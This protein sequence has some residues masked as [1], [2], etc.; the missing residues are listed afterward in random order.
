[1][2]N[3]ESTFVHGLFEKSQFD[4]YDV[5]FHPIFTNSAWIWQ[6]DFLRW[7]PDWSCSL[8]LLKLVP[9]GVICPSLR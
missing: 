3:D 6:N 7:S 8:S 1:M 5:I 9:H 4:G 2:K